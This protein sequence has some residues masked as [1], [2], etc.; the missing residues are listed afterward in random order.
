MWSKGGVEAMVTIAT[1]DLVPSG[2]NLL[3]DYAGFAKL[4][5]ACREF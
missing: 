3:P 5:Q 1:A 4:E 2:A